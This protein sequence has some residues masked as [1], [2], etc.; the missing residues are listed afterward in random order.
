LVAKLMGTLTT[1]WMA[2]QTEPLMAR[3]WSSAALSLAPWGGSRPGGSGGG[4]P[5]SS[6]TEV[7][8]GRRQRGSERGSAGTGARLRHRDASSGAGIHVHGS[9]I[10]GV[11]GETTR[12][13]ARF[14][15]TVGS[16]LSCAG[17]AIWRAPASVR[18][19]DSFARATV[20][21]G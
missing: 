19:L 18:P 13:E 4:G 9:K 20:C 1:L 10:P 2:V 6:G 17:D 3:S 7:D 8:P 5:I 12:H 11:T 14:S 21:V 16:V 15:R